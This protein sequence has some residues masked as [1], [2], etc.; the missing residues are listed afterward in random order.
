M[1]I[2]ENKELIEQFILEKEEVRA[3][4]EYMAYQFIHPEQEICRQIVK[5]MHDYLEVEE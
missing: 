3:L 1:E 4:Y 5:R 2:L